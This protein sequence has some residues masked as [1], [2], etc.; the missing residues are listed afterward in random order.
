[1]ALESNAR[2]KRDAA[3]SEDARQI[4]HIAAGLCAL[5]LRW[6]TWFEATMLASFAVTFNMYGLHRIGGAQLFRADEHGRWR[7]KSG[8]VLYPA[9]ILGLLLLL[10]SRPD[11]VAASWGVL[12]AGDGAAT[13]IG[14]RVPLRPL[15]WNSNKSLGG[16]LAFAVFGS[17]AAVG[18][19]WWCAGRIVPPTFWWFPFVAGISGAVLAA[20]V[21]T[22]PISLDDNVSVAATAAAV[23]WTLSIV[24]EDVLRDFVPLALAALP[25]A[26]GLNAVVAAAGYVA[27]TVSLSGALVGAALGTVIFVAT[28]WQG[29]TLLIATFAIAVITSRL[30]LGRKQALK[31]EEERGGRRGAGNAIANT[32][33]AA[34]AAVL[35]VT[36]YAH[37]PALIA[38]VAAL[39]AGGSDTVASEIGKAWGRRT[40]LVTNMKKVRP[41]TPGAMSL[42]GTVA[43]IFG[44]L[45][46]AG[47]GVGL[48]LVEAEVL[49][50]IVVAA[51]IGALIES[52]LGATLERR[53]VVNNDVLNFVNTATAAYVAIQLME[54]L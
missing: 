41:G 8:I 11:I 5:L 15:P 22:I 13:L 4:V 39:A 38:F 52:I 3:L 29:W 21:E 44:A 48:G 43:G 27:R 2:M 54:V 33:I 45:V 25:V 7:V 9:S 10:P 35:S 36:T 14:R 26:L 46:L 24:S 23:M 16:S 32:G 42:E 53:G 12:A 17:L 40:F 51:S 19:L 34:A 50:A 31:I 18:L 30:G 47:A 20:S 28:G 6:L 1:M 37:D 49:P